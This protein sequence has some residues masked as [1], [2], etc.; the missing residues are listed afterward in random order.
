MLT[1][2]LQSDRS[3]ASKTVGCPSLMAPL[4]T[5]FAPSP[6]GPL[7]RGHIYAA[8][9]AHHFAK[10]SGGKFTLRIDDIDHT[11]CRDQFT[12]GICNDLKWLG[13][14]WDG[15]V[16]F[17]TKRL[18]A[19]RAALKT[20]QRLDLVYPCFLSRKELVNIL[21]APHGHPDPA[22]IRDT[23]KL[24]PHNEQQR[25]AKR[26]ESLLTATGSSRRGHTTNFL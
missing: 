17:Q 6:T 23:D 4:H 2:L 26:K 24:L 13:L 14:Q 16:P 9:I 22:S 21:S 12:K 15:S 25:R 3:E 5:R 20:L 8:Q 10:Y 18:A 11:R 1:Q 7:H 19:Y